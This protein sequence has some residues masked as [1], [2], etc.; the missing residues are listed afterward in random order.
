M[1][2]NHS[3]LRCLPVLANVLGRSYGI[4]V[5][6]GG[7]EACTDGS[8][9]RLPDFPDQADETFLGLVRGYIDHEAAHIRYTDFTVLHDQS[10]T[11]LIKH[12]WNIFEDWRV[13]QR[14]ASVFPGCQ[15]NFNWLIRYLFMGK[16]E[17]SF[18]LLSWLLMSVRSWS[19]AE[20]SSQ[21]QTLDKRI[22]IDY[23]GLL[24]K[25]EAILK[26]VKSN[27]PDT[28]TAMA[29]AKQVI[30]CLID[31]QEKPVQNMENN[32]HHLS[33]TDSLEPL[34]NVKA[35]QLP[36]GMDEKVRHELRTQPISTQCNRVAIE[37]EKEISALSAD[38]L[39]ACNLASVGLRNRL[40][41]LLQSS[42][43]VKMR[44]QRTGSLAPNLLHRAMIN[45]SRLFV[46]YDEK[47]ALN[48][49]VHILLDASGSM[50][51]RMDLA[52]QACYAL[53]T[54]LHQSGI[55]V[56]MTAFPGK[57]RQTPTVVPLLR[58]GQ[59]PSI[60]M[61]PQVFGCTPLGE[62]LWW[63]IPKLYELSETRKIVVVITDGAPDDPA[64]VKRAL[65]MGRSTG[66]E[67]IGLGICSTDIVKLMP[68][69]SGSI[70]DLGELMPVLFATIQRTVI[71]QTA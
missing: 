22:D 71:Q 17:G 49:A 62:A 70:N 47:P 59:R 30:D 45:D 61:R 46:K 65:D 42:Q 57:S 16:D 39:K 34:I 13:E 12:I 56:G 43:R 69:R 67:F 60:K 55:N 58:H 52:T 53:A 63:M 3:I 5:E 21:V 24:P 66:I 8:T 40:S 38:Q 31:H 23:P 54:S 28:A 33:K 2:Q 41:G 14:L 25:L 7:R 48:T 44:Q 50:R 51:E 36:A 1:E 68:G 4:K 18:V 20:L 35:D 64:M 27:C 10:V 11:P 6:I 19:V 32:K 15:K 26:E 37:G 29:Y 9:I